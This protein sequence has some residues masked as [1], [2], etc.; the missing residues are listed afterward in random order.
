MWIYRPE[1]P[2][3]HSAVSYLDL[4]C[5]EVRGISEMEVDPAI[6]F[7]FWMF[8]ERLDPPLVILIDE[9]LEQHIFG[10]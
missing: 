2:S 4:P 10:R 3:H 6:E 8:L 7:G 1:P 9:D 5:F